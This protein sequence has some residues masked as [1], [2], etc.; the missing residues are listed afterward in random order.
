MKVVFAALGALVLLAS[1]AVAQ[2]GATVEALVADGY[3]VKGVI[4]SNA[5]PGI[6]LQKG[7]ELVMCFVAETRDSAEIV[8]QYCK[9]VK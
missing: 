6:L 1:A 4:A 3:E 8:T 2:E 9:P 7:G 5:G